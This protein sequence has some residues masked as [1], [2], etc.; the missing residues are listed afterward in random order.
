MHLLKTLLFILMLPNV[1]SKFWYHITQTMMSL[2]LKEIDLLLNVYWTYNSFTG[3]KLSINILRIKKIYLYKHGLINV[4]VFIAYICV[5]VSY[6][7]IK[8]NQSK[9][10]LFLFLFVFSFL[11]RFG[12]IFLLVYMHNGWLIIVSFLKIS[13]PSSVRCISSPSINIQSV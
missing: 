6:D 7:D 13:F 5:C 9:Y 4:C 8:E 12:G 3:R 2:Y 11:G 10:G 1:T